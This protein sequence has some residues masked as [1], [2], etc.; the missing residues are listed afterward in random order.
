M[1]ETCGSAALNQRPKNDPIQWN[2]GDGLCFLGH[3]FTGAYWWSLRQ[4]PVF[5]KR[6]RGM[7]QT[8]VRLWMTMIG[9]FTW[10]VSWDLFPKMKQELSGPHLDNYAGCE[11]L[12]NG[13][14]R[15]HSYLWPQSNHEAYTCL[16]F[17]ICILTLYKLSRPISKG[18]HSRYKEGTCISHTQPFSVWLLP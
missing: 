6:L 8:K 9:Q 10:F 18:P 16:Y 11:P 4:R 14:R 2:Q 5:S 15:A 3:T 1:D 13:P 12:S 17:C 7:L